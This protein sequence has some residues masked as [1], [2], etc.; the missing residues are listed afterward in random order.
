MLTWCVAPPTGC[1][2]AYLSDAEDAHVPESTTPAVNAD[3]RPAF[4]ARSNGR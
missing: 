1:H 2:G 4:A 3:D